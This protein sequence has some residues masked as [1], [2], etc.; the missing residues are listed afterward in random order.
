MKLPRY[1]RN[2]N[3]SLYYQRDIPTRL[4]DFSNK[5]TFTH[6]L[7]LRIHEATESAISKATT[8]STEAFELYLK[9][10]TNSDPDAFTASEMDLAIV[11]HLR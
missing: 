4:R 3:G 6:P 7:K 9:F 1:V 2:L 11:E 5:K 8:K 10:L